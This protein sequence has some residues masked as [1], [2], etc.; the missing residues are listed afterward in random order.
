MG[1]DEVASDFEGRAVLRS[2]TPDL[3]AQQ[4]SR[5]Q[6][7]PQDLTPLLF[8]T[9]KP[10]V[11]RIAKADVLSIF[12]Y[13]EQEL[14]L[15]AAAVAGSPD[16]SV[17]PVGYTVNDQGQIQFPFVGQ[18]TVEGLTEVQARDVLI[19]ALKKY[20]ANPQLTL[21]V[22]AYRGLKVYVEGE[23]R[24]PG[25]LYITDLPMTLAEALSRT[26]GVTV[27]GDRS[28]IEVRRRG[29]LFPV[30]LVDLA[31]L[32]VT[33]DHLLLQSGDSVR[34][35]PRDETKISVLGEVIKPGMVPT[36]NGNL[37]LNEAL[38]EAGGLSGLSA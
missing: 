9:D 4:K 19:A 1:T 16:S 12:I 30:N 33:A 11:Y 23:V 34:V 20:M 10:P 36:R 32:G 38:A 27:L 26:G 31:K 8:D 22:Q 21:R 18:V 7:F 15:P 25:P 37:S 17:I 35:T 6:V 29:T 3:I 2:I 5:Q 14:N 24:L 28:R 13:R